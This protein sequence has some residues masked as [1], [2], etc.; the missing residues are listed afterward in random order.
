MTTTDETARDDSW[1]R[2][3]IVGGGAGGLGL[4]TRL[5]DKMGK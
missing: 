1:H 5:G 4:A 3:V 2:I